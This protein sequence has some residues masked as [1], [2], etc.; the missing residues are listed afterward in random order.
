MATNV[1]VKVLKAIGQYSPGQEVEV[2]EATAK[3]LC[4]P[5]KHND[6]TRV[7]ESINAML[8]SDFEALKN[9]PVNKGGMT[10]GELSSMGIKNVVQTPAD[11][12]LEKKFKKFAEQNAAGFE[13]SNEEDRSLRKKSARG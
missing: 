13:E 11:P 2:D 10:Q 9:Q 12:V 7:V 3:A 1:K 5:R 6:G 8:M 4:E